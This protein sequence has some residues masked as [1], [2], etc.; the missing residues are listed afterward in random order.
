MK[1]TIPVL[2]LISAISFIPQIEAQ[3]K[4]PQKAKK[5]KKPKKVKKVIEVDPIRDET[6]ENDGLTILYGNAMMEKL[7]EEG[8]F[9]SYLQLANAGKKI[10]FRSCAYSGDTVDF[11]IRASR[12][13]LHLKYLLQNWQSDR[14]IMAF[15]ANESYAGAPGLAAFEKNLKN[16][17]E[18]ITERHSE[19]ELILASP[20][21]SEKDSS[22]TGPDLVKRN[23]DIKLYADSMKKIAAKHNIKFV[24]LFTPSAE[25]FNSSD[26]VYTVNGQ[27]LSDKGSA[28]VGK[29]LASAINSKVDTVKSDSAA[30]KAI[31]KIVQRK[32]LEVSQAYHPA[33]GISYY[34]LRARPYEYNY[35]IPHH[36]KLAN[37][38]DQ[39]TWEQANNLETTVSLPELPIYELK[40]LPNSKPKRGLGIIKSAKEDLKDFTLAPGFEVNCFASS[41]DYPELINPLQMQF[42]GR[43]R[44]WV[45]CFASYPHPLPGNVS[46]DTILIF[47]DTNNDGKADKKTTFAAGLDLPDGF[48]FH[49]KGIVVT[50]SRKLIYLED[51]NGDSKA[52]I[53]KEILRGFDNTDTHHS[54]YLQRS[55]HGGVILSEALFHRGQFET[56]SGTFRTK[57]SVI[58]SLDMDTRKLTAERQTEAPN[59]W[60]V[61]YNQYGECIQFYGGGQIIDAETHN[62]ATPIG[63]A[64]PS[65]LG[66]PFRYDKG[67]SATFVNSPVFPKNWQGGFITSHLLSKNE[68]NY[69]PLKLVEGAY[70][71]AQKKTTILKS[72]NKVFRPTDVL[73]GNDGA[74]YI[75][76]FYYPIIGH[77]QHS[78]RHKDRDYANGRIWRVTHTDTPA[79][80]VENLEKKTTS[81]LINKLKDPFL[82]IRQVARNE[83]A[84]KPNTE[85]NTAL[86]KASSTHTRDDVYALELLWLMERQK[87]FSDTSLIK[88][89]VASS[90]IKIQRSAVRSLRWWADALAAD[91]EPILTKLAA[92]SDDRVKMGVITVVSHLQMKDTKWS[93][94]GDKV[95]A[96]PATPLHYMKTMLTWID[97]PGLAPEFPILSVDPAAYL[98]DTDWEKTDKGYKG[99]L[100]F[101]S[102]QAGNLN[103]GHEGNAY[104]NLNINDSPL[105][106]AT[107]GPHS[108]E[109]QNSFVVKKGINKVEFF[110]TKNKEYARLVNSNFKSYITDS[111]GKKPKSITLSS[112]KEESQTWGKQYNDNQL[113]NW[114]EFA[115]KTFA[116]N[117]SNCH[118]TDADTAIAPALRGLLG[119]K[120][121][122][123]SKDGIK[124]E[125]T[126][127]EAYLRRAIVN[128]MAEYREGSVPAMVL[129]DPLS[130]KEVDVLVK[131]IKQLN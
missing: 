125:V 38:L 101:N 9:E 25:L 73:F 17:L 51:T 126:I 22:V 40:K 36:L 41:E 97:R 56:L 131:W 57:D 33:N 128:P 99:H 89:L 65:A 19:S 82:S 5:A 59:P 71:A 90:D 98:T 80:A 4:T 16:Y 48:I 7:Q 46:N 47:E 11:R 69:T 31:Q 86:T 1:I 45:T 52:D 117:C 39:A 72:S 66:M 21:A 107:G 112:S 34:G 23:A 20:I 93:A 62:V 91:L 37:T 120:Q 88:R 100:Y 118:N 75:T 35:E 110:V 122:V 49:D 123:I 76:D 119:K 85:V 109:S 113:N 15:G 44:L 50:T 74:L 84:K 30:F 27:N 106:L 60:K 61:S 6:I 43:G 111:K 28:A 29:L 96:Q 70:R 121:T 92:S 114:E 32:A 104:L 102:S 87:N 63:S 42:D 18:L 68:I 58:M 26:G 24:D 83:L 53:K 3:D 12:F 78:L 116:K 77:A 79:L 115:L 2:A 95:L 14:V 81:E 13:G 103:L 124:R 127:D 67:C 54:G 130:E 8:S 10:Q 129:K 108:K 105:L 64:A 55:P 94:I